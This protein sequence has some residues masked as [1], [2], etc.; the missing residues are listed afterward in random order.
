MIVMTGY[1]LFK[2]KQGESSATMCKVSTNPENLLL[3]FF[4]FMVC[5]LSF[6]YS[7]TGEAALRILGVSVED[8]GVYTCVA[9]NVTGSVT[10]SASLRVS[11]ELFWHIYHAHSKSFFFCD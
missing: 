8:S 6:Y 2:V 3:G 4:Y 7:E 1:Y 9:T 10:S 11:G 5:F